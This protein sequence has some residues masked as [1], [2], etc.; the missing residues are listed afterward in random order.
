MIDFRNTP[1]DKQIISQ[2]KEFMPYWEKINWE[3][4]KNKL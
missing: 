4:K 3:V 2:I 1:K